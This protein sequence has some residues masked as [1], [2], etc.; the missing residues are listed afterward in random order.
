MRPAES[1]ISDTP[2]HRVTAAFAKR[3]GQV[4][5]RKNGSI[6]VTGAACADERAIIEDE[7]RDLVFIW[8]DLTRIGGLRLWDGPV[9]ADPVHQLLDPE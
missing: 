5:W 2:A 7:A 4:V 8:A 6:L 1:N 9:I 3:G